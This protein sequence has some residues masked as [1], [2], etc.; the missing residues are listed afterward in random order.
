MTEN[1]LINLITSTKIIK[2]QEIFFADLDL[3]IDEM[4]LLYPFVVTKNG[5]LLHKLH[6]EL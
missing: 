2:V 6:L 5:E 1:F 4:G 3:T